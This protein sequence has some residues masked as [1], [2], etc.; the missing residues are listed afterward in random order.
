MKSSLSLVMCFALISGCSTVST[1]KLARAEEVRG[2]T[3]LGTITTT[4][5]L[6][7]VFKNMSYEGAVSEALKKAEQM[8]ATHF[9][10]DE[11]S[12]AHFL[13]FS[14]TV[15]GNAYRAPRR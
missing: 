14:E 7:G 4:H 10:L 3:F 13:G 6:G 15:R 9:V 12:K 1:V 5:P 11:N 2:Y 8:G